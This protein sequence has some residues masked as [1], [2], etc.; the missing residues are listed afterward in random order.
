MISM[1]A[2]R[3]LLPALLSLGALMLAGCGD[4]ATSAAAKA[5]SAGA[6]ASAAA[7]AVGS[8]AASAAASGSAAASAP[9]A[10]VTELAGTSWNL[11]AFA[12]ESGSLVPAS[13]APDQGT[14]TFAADGTFSGSTGCNRVAGTYKQDG[15]NLTLAP[16]PVTKKACPQDLTTQEDAVLAAFP[17]VATFTSN[18]TLEL[19]S[20]DGIALLD[21]EPGTAGLAGTKWT[22]TG[23]NNGK[24]AV[25][26]AAGVEKV[27][28]EFGADGNVSGV[29]A[30]NNYNGPY[31]ETAPDG[32]TFGTLATTMKTC[33]DALNTIEQ[34]YLAAL[35]NVATYQIDGSTLTL[36]DKD[37]A[38]Q[39]TYQQSAA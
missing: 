33:D 18:Q 11:T 32:L 37:G 28:I 6:A 23:I 39:V 30:C 31:T 8:G 29:S 36:R 16:G 3:A 35:A 10:S 38:T 7:S 17:K 26:S 9:A 25:V 22:A 12:D 5:S 21:Y 34:Q 24:Q 20:A 19:L 2:K 1:S 15:G 14:L 4:A 13:T 27:T